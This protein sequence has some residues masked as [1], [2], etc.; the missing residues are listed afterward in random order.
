MRRR[1]LVATA[2][3]GLGC[4]S[5]HGKHG[6][7]YKVA[8]LT[9][10]GSRIC[11]AMKDGAVRCWGREGDRA[12][13]VPT[14][15]PDLHDAAS[16][17]V[18]GAAVCAL[19]RGGAVTCSDGSR[20]EAATG[21]ACDGD[22][23]CLVA[24][25]HVRCGVGAALTDV[26]GTDGA[27]ALAM[28]GGTTCATF[29]DGSAKCWGSGKRGQLGNGRFED[30]DAPDAVLASGIRSICVGGEHACAVL[31]DETAV[32]FGANDDGEL[33]T[34]DLAP[35]AV[36]KAVP[37]VDIATHIACGVH[38]T[39][40]RMGDSTVHCWGKNDVH[41]TSLGP[42][43]HVLAQSIVFGLYE[44]DGVAAGDDFTCARMTDR[45]LRCFGVNDWGQLADGTTEIRNVPTPIRY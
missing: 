25:G 28:G 38:H 21:L 44:A 27:V 26:A 23:R 31:R 13:L 36:P 9:A 15:V 16:V 39:C 20:Y 1:L 5:C 4:A 2:A 34:G 8:E 12:E 29:A 43:A 3:L 41:Q 6:D 17:C 37:S 32:C 42:S 10:A 45:W 19:T 22:R 7:A 40:A 30:R 18:S 35:S 14:L 33:G 11:A 24:E